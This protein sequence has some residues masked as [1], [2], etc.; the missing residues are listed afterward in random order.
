M[1][2]K[3]LRVSEL[4]NACV[5]YVSEERDEAGTATH[6]QRPRYDFGAVND[7]D[8]DKVTATL[9]LEFADL[10]RVSLCVE[11][12]MYLERT[13]VNRTRTFPDATERTTDEGSKTV[14]RH[15][16]KD[17]VPT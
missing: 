12:N 11:N 14:Y 7:A 1:Q 5:R 3:S 8:N 4:F 16:N 17:N 13:S 9:S 10:R 15:L 6:I 2:D